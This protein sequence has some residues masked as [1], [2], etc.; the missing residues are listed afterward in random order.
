MRTRTRSISRASSIVL[1]NQIIP[2]YYAKAD[3]KLPLAWIQL[4]RES[5]RTLSQRS[6]PT[7]MVSEYNER[8][9]EP[10]PRLASRSPRT[11]APPRRRSASGRTTSASNGRSSASSNT[12]SPMARTQRRSARVFYVVEK[13]P[14]PRRCILVQSIRRT[15]ACRPTTAP[16]ESGRIT[17]PASRSRRRAAA[18][19]WRLRLHRHASRLRQRVFGLNIRII[20]THEQLTQ[21]HELRLITWAR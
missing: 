8:L 20:P 15:S 14:S 18:R 10:P 3:G 5:M 2:L 12:A 6:T 19:Q 16:S 9:Y 11:I 1:E 21:A 17:S 4:M 13:L 7:A